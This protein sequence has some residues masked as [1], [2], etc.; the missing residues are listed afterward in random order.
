MQY[1]AVQTDL[2]TLPE[3][4]QRLRI[5]RS[6]LYRLFWRGELKPIPVGGRRLVSSR[7]IDAY[8]QRLEEASNG[9]TRQA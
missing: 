7:A 9:E 8:I 1:Q 4:A 2:L 3:A 5:S 6:S